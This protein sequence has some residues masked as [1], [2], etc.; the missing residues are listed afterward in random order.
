MIF[1]C[2]CSQDVTTDLLIDKLRPHAATFRFDV[3]RRQD[4]TWEFGPL[5]WRCSNSSGD[6][7]SRETLSC[8]LFR[9]PIFVEPIDIPAH[10][11]LENWCRKEMLALFKDLYDECESAG[12][13]ALVHPD[14]DAVGKLRQVPEWRLFRGRRPELPPGRNWVVKSLTS[15]LIGQ[16]KIFIV[17]KAEPE[18]LD[19]AYPWFIQENV[20]G[21]T[22]VSAAYV[23]GR[24]F[25]SEI[26]REVLGAVD[27]RLETFR[28][29]LKWTPV[30]LPDA[31][32]SAI[33][34]FMAEVGL[35][36][37]RFDFIRK[38]GELCFLEVNPNGQWA[39]L[40]EKDERGL[41]SAVAEEIMAVER[42]GRTLAD[43]R[44]P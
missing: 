25:A 8:F 38:D 37:G 40:D 3:D 19:P 9:K 14:C 30:E 43:A 2:T 41:V 6:M 11:N 7:V 29:N 31:E 13:V 4:F 28:R 24:I 17:R 33:R 23:N 32:Q 15:T 26:S 20:E 22:E 42:R 16:G 21:Q 10:G 36:F 18:S 5:S 1:I 27:S 44:R 12:L 39:W 35:S 34:G